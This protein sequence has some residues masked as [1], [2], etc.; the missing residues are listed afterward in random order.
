MSMPQTGLCDMKLVLVENRNHV[1]R[2]LSRLVEVERKKSIGYSEAI[3]R[4]D[5]D[6]NMLQAGLHDVQ[7]TVVGGEQEPCVEGSLQVS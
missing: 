1:W 2:D 5:G 4:Q 7:E 6:V 3:F